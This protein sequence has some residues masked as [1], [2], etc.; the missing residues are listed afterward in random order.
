VVVAPIQP[1]SETFIA[2]IRYRKAVSSGVM[3]LAWW[4]LPLLLAAG[5]DEPIRDPRAPGDQA[6]VER[7]LL[8]LRLDPKRDATPGECDDLVASDLLVTIGG[9]KMPVTSVERVPRPDRH[10]LLLDISESA[11]GRRAEAKRSAA[12][13]AR[14]VMTPGIDAA[15]VRTRAAPSAASVHAK[16]TSLPCT[17]RRGY[18]LAR[19]A[20][21]LD[22]ATAGERALKST[23]LAVVRQDGVRVVAADV[24]RNVVA[25]ADGG[26]GKADR[27]GQSE[28]QVDTL[29]G[30]HSSLLSLVGS[31]T[32]RPSCTPSWA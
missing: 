10:W 23:G 16:V 9:A 18:P 3:T 19:L 6:I 28:N 11:E 8:T 29:G 26:A 30:C 4:I 22:T 14:K 12:E 20:A 31:S 1:P 27:H 15:A 32:T 17:A 2:A 21:R 5:R 24:E 25:L 7:G 13:Y